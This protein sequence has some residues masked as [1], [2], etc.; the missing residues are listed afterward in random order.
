VAVSALAAAA[1]LRVL[2][3]NV[4]ACSAGSPAFGKRHG[5]RSDS[6]AAQGVG[7]GWSEGSLSTRQD[8]AP[9]IVSMTEL[10]RWLPCPSSRADSSW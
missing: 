8:L 4:D 1:G 9:R 2:D 3:G 6:L 10:S 7:W 5:D